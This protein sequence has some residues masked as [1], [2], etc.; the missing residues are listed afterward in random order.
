VC[1]LS[2]KTNNFGKDSHPKLRLLTFHGLSQRARI[3]LASFVSWDGWGNRCAM[4]NSMLLI[5]SFK[6]LYMK[7]HGVSTPV[8]TFLWFVGTGGQYGVIPFSFGINFFWYSCENPF[9]QSLETKLRFP[10]WTVYCPQKNCEC[11][12]FA[13]KNSLRNTTFFFDRLKRLLVVQILEVTVYQ[14]NEMQNIYV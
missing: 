4:W 1:I 12:L 11:F 9:C 7:F 3:D 14:E 13:N 10:V 5:F 6:T 8:I 2:S